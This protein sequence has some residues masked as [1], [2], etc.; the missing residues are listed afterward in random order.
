MADVGSGYPHPGRIHQG[1]PKRSPGKLKV[2]SKQ[3][4]STC[5]R[6][7]ADLSCGY[8]HTDPRQIAISNHTGKCIYTGK[9]ID[10]LLPTKRKQT[11]KHA[12]D[13]S[14]PAYDTTFFLK[15]TTTNVVI[16]YSKK[17]LEI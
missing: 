6:N 7:Y 10:F 8:N 4:T 16:L 15:T 11:N 9:F 13:N 2:P 17:K 5:Q 3:T 12:H 1:L 14:F